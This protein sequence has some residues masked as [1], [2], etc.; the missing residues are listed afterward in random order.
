MISLAVTLLLL[1]A[2][3]ASVLAISSESTERLL[4]GGALA[5][6]GLGAAVELACGG[7]YGFLMIAV[8]L[9]SDLAI[10]LFFRTQRLLP[11]QPP[12]S[13]RNDRLF[14][15]FFLW[16]A[17]CAVAGSAVQLGIAA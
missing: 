15:L 6:L 1:L 8:F 2:L 11:A 13:A 7:Y 9:M 3:V 16:L 10:Y 17:L 5:S 12:P 14:R 4:W